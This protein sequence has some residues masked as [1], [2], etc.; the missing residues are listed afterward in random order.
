MGSRQAVIRKSSVRLQAVIRLAKQ[1]LGSQIAM[2]IYLMRSFETESFFSL[3][4][5]RITPQI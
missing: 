5:G 2:Q 3:V 4:I 1:S